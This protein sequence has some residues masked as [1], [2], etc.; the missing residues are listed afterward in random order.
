MTFAQWQSL[1][2][3]ELVLAPMSEVPEMVDQNKAD[4]TS[5]DDLHVMCLDEAFSEWGI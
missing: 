5:D 1:G 3:S 4:K 2:S